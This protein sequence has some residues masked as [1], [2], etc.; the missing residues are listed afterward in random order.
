MADPLFSVVYSGRSG[1]LLLVRVPLQ[2]SRVKP[3]EL[4]GIEQWLT[5]PTVGHQLATLGDA[6]IDAGDRLRQDLWQAGKPVMADEERLL[7]VMAETRMLRDWQFWQ[8]LPLHVREHMVVGH[9]VC[10][11]PTHAHPAARVTI[12][13]RKGV[14]RWERNLDSFHQRLDGLE[15]RWLGLT[16]IGQEGRRATP[17][18][19]LQPRALPARE[20]AGVPQMRSGTHH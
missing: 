7:A 18:A 12:L 5:V 10:I 2:R 20:S 4:R 16:G 13:V 11:P 14:W 6:E 19:C 1:E 8:P 3:M 9:G 17:G 15:D